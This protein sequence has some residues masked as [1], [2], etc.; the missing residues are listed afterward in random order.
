MRPHLRPCSE[1][2]DSQP[3]LFWLYQTTVFWAYKSLE[4]QG[5]FLLFLNPS[6]TEHSARMAPVSWAVTHS[7]PQFLPFFSEPQ[8]VLWNQP[9]SSS[10]KFPGNGVF[11]K[12]AALTYCPL[13]CRCTWRWKAISHVRCWSPTQYSASVW[14]PHTLSHEGNCQQPQCGVIHPDLLIRSQL[15]FS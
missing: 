14:H 6:W 2:P 1:S 9:K 4:G 3:Q 10:L 11:L 15:P 12:I 5:R 13:L 7:G 8:P